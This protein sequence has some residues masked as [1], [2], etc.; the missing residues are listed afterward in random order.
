[1]GVIQRGY[2]DLT[3]RF[4]SVQPGVHPTLNWDITR[5]TCLSSPRLNRPIFWSYP[6][7][8]NPRRQEVQIQSFIS[9]IVDL[10]ATF[11][12]LL[13]GPSKGRMGFKLH[14]VETEKVGCQK[15]IGWSFIK[16]EGSPN[17]SDLDLPA[18]FYLLY[19]S[20]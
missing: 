9:N 20:R 15:T 19:F 5:S 7:V 1:M 6:S 2:L 14:D 13:D 3:P 4:S 12:S 11:V 10:V 17:T 8:I 16:S 18:Y